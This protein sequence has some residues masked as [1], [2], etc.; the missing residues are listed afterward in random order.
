MSTLLERRILGWRKPYH[1]F[2][3]LTHT[4]LWAV[5]KRCCNRTYVSLS[6]H[7]V[8]ICIPLL[9]VFCFCLKR[10]EC[11][12]VLFVKF[13]LFFVSVCK[14]HNLLPLQFLLLLLASKKSYILKVIVWN[15]KSQFDI[16]KYRIAYNMTRQGCP[17]KREWVF[18]YVAIKHKN[19]IYDCYHIQM[20]TF[21]TSFI[22]KKTCV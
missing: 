19:K 10:E 14:N 1:H 8:Y 7:I 18:E 21:I 2:F 9:S 4:I 6:L 15:F 20:I 11:W 22:K 5:V 16:P 17:W 13:C 12:R 3:C